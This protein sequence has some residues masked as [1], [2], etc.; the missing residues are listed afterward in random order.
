MYNTNKIPSRDYIEHL[1]R[2]YPKGTR[3]QLGCMEDAMP[4]PARFTGNRRVYRR[5]GPDSCELGLRTQPCP[6][7]RCGLVQQIVRTHKNKGW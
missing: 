7:P 4:V 6:Y 3:V 2:K 1:R 5:Y